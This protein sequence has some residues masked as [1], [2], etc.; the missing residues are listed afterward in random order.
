MSRSQESKSSILVIFFVI[1]F[2]LIKPLKSF[3]NRNILFLVDIVCFRHFWRFLFL[4]H[5]KFRTCHDTYKNT[6]YRP[7]HCLFKHIKI[8]H[9]QTLT[10]TSRY[11]PSYII[12][13]WNILC[14]N[15]C[16]S[17]LSKDI[18]VSKDKV[19]IWGTS[20]KWRTMNIWLKSKVL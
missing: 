4:L 9:L 1:I 17:Y 11:C 3:N 6:M 13:N 8:M 19:R 20:Y 14:S 18:E 12:I 15:Y 2:F 7:R 10:Y 5:S 16:R